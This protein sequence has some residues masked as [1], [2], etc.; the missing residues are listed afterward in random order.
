[1]RC[2]SLQLT[3]Q[4]GYWQVQLL[5]PLTCCMQHE[6]CVWAQV[7]E[8]REDSRQWDKGLPPP[9]TIVYALNARGQSAL[10]AV[11]LRA[12]CKLP[13]FRQQSAAANMAPTALSTASLFVASAC[14][15][16]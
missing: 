7:Y 9:R 3:Y 4:P 13:A 6:T 16:N 1:M 14:C 2:G 11:R 10:A 12:T 8:K 5:I 15:C